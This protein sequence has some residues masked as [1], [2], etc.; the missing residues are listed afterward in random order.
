MTARMRGLVF[1]F[2]ISVPVF[3]TSSDEAWLAG[4]MPCDVK[5]AR[6]RIRIAMD[7][8]MDCPEAQ[9]DFEVEMIQATQGKAYVVLEGLSR[10]FVTGTENVVGSEDPQLVLATACVMQMD[11]IPPTSAEIMNFRDADLMDL[12]ATTLRNLGGLSLYPNL[13]ELF[14]GEEKIPAFVKFL[15]KDKNLRA[16]AEKIEQR[17][18]TKEE[19]KEYLKQALDLEKELYEGMPVSERLVQHRKAFESAIKGFLEGRVKTPLTPDEL[20][21][22]GRKDS[23]DEKR[24]MLTL[25]RNAFIERSIADKFCE[26]RLHDKPVIARLG[27]VHVED[28]FKSLAARF[29]SSKSDPKIFLE[30]DARLLEYASAEEAFGS[31]KGGKTLFQEH[32]AFAESVPNRY[33]PISNQN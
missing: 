27:S 23:W 16:L 26:T 2:L 19:W 14:G 1:I 31:M 24:D 28:I 30:L 29:T 25:E 17:R 6:N 33:Q 21:V 20:R 7:L 12:H 10:D 32:R 22:L 11:I 3:A 9:R 4:L 18:D 13:K 15:L 8:H 5:A